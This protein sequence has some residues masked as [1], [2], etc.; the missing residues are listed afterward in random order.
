MSEVVL[1]DG[2]PLST[3]YAFLGSEAELGFAELLQKRVFTGQVF[4]PGIHLGLQGFYHE[5][6]LAERTEHPL[7]D[8][9]ELQEMIHEVF[10]TSQILEFAKDVQAKLEAFAKLTNKIQE[11][12]SDPVTNNDLKLADEAYIFFKTLKKLG[13]S[14]SYGHFMQQSHKHIPGPKV[15][16]QRPKLK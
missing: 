15:H 7:P 14:D 3:K 2:S 12:S 16:I 9:F 10:Q 5:S 1:G 11:G 6:I 4:K 8:H 13:D